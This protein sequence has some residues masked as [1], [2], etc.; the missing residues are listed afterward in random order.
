MPELHVEWKHL[1]VNGKTCPRCSS[2]GSAVRD[3]VK[4]LERILAPH[5]IH[6]RYSET[7]E[8]TICCDV[9]GDRE[10]RAVELNETLYEAIPSGLIVKAGLAAAPHLLNNSGCCESSL[11]DCCGD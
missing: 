1:S 8:K 9:C 11:A 3:A 10:C 7:T 4:T 5:G 2:T 6:V